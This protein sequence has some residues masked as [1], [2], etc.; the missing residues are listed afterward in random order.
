MNYK[1]SENLIKPKM[2]PEKRAKLEREIQEFIDNPIITQY[3]LDLLFGDGIL[4]AGPS[5]ISVNWKKFYDMDRLYR[6]DDISNH[7]V[8]YLKHLKILSPNP[9][10]N[11]SVQA[12]GF[13]LCNPRCHLLPA[14]FTSKQDAVEYTNVIAEGAMYDVWVTKGC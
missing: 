6:N 3:E 9:R 8:D 5:G 11:Y 13:I 7:A 2:K 4:I 10:G 12:D 14:F 1:I